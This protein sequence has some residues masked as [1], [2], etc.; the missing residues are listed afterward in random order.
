[1]SENTFS[2]S[3]ANIDGGCSPYFA[4]STYLSYENAK[5]SQKQALENAERDIE[6]EKILVQKKEAYADK[7]RDE[8]WAFQKEL[9]ELKRAH[10]KEQTAKKLENDSDILDLA[11]FFKD[12]PLVLD[13]NTIVQSVYKTQSLSFII[14][15]HAAFSKIDPLSQAYGDIVDHVKCNLRALGVQDE[16][17]LTFK[18]DAKRVG[19]PALANVF[20]MMQGFPVIMVMPS[21]SPDGQHLFFYA[22]I[23]N[24]DSYLPLSR[25]LFEIEYTSDRMLDNGYRKEKLTE[26]I[27]SET[28]IFGVFRDTYALI[29]TGNTPSF[30]NLASKFGLGDYPLI[31][32]FACKEYDSLCSFSFLPS[33]SSYGSG[34]S[35]TSFNLINAE[36]IK[37]LASDALSIIQNL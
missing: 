9:I 20:A 10:K 33:E 2:D 17:V 37:R 6:F 22:G 11:L 36:Q 5:R 3:F 4:L 13:I 19:G 30:P 29:A 24:D 28:T 32:A 23:W 16:N 15:P 26:I 7:K 1:M 8:E 25:K 14:A 27:C 31:K 21:I 12:W 18:N 35:I 34:S